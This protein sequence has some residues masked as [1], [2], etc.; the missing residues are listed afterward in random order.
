[1]TFLCFDTFFSR[2]FTLATQAV[3]FIHNFKGSVPCV[4]FRA[5]PG[6]FQVLCGSTEQGFTTLATL[7]TFPGLQ[8]VARDIIPAALSARRKAAASQPPG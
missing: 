4:L 1:M 3:Y 2:F 7:E 8:A 6:P 5:Y